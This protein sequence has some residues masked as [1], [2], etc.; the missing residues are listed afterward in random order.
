[1]QS[2][3]IKMFWEIDLKDI[4]KYCYEKI[5][6]NIDLHLAYRC[7]PKYQ[8]FFASLVKHSLFRSS[9]KMTYLTTSFSSVENW[10]W[11]Q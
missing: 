7:S 11:G 1:M 8:V 9:Q 10:P 5:L 6:I 3:M 4:E 2:I